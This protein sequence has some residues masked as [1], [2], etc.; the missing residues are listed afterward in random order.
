MPHNNFDDTSHDVSDRTVNIL[1]ALCVIITIGVA[2]VVTQHNK[3]LEKCRI[4][5]IQQG[6]TVQEINEVCK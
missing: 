6:A 5:M 4:A 2:I 3:L 1:I